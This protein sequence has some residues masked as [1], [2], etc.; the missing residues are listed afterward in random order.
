M[1]LILMGISLTD[2][3]KDQLFRYAKISLQI[4]LDVIICNYVQEILIIC[5]SSGRHEK[6]VIHFILNTDFSLHI[7]HLR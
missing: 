3:G 2:K 7:S 1:Q 6:D 5:Y 4:I